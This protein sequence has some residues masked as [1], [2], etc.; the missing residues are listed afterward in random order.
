M[1]KK[2]VFMLA[3]LAFVIGASESKAQNK[4]KSS[5]NQETQTPEKEDSL[6]WFYFQPDPFN[7]DQVVVTATRTQKRIKDVPVITQVVTSKQILERGVTNIQDLLAQEVP[8]LNFQQVGFGT[9][10]DIQGLG[11]KH[12]LFLIDG[13]RIAGENGGNID[14]SRIN[15]SNV[16]RIEIVKGASSALYGSQA[17]GGVINIITKNAKQPFE[18]SGGVKYTQNNQRN[19]KGVSKED[20][21]WKHKRHVD[22]PNLNSNLSLGFNFGDFSM[23]TDV[24]Y[25][26][27]DGY[28]MYDKSELVKYYPKL[29]TTITQPINEIP[30][31]ISGY[32]DVN[33]SHKMAYKYKDKLKV[34]L[35]GS[36]YMLNKYDFLQD[37]IFEKSLDY[38]YGGYF[39]YNFNPKSNLKVSFHADNYQRSDKF[40]KMKGGNLI[41]KNNIMQPRL[42]YTDSQ[43][44]NQVMTAGIEFFRE[45]LY[46]DKFE[47][48]VYE[49]KAQWYL[50]AFFQ[51]DW[52]INKKLSLIGGL[53]ADY[54]KNYGFNVTPKVSFMAKLNPFILR[55]NYARGYRSPTIKELYMNWDHLGMFQ[56]IGNSQLK[57]ESNN[58]ISISGEY[59]NRW[60]NFN[61]N[62]YSNWFRN[63]IEGMWKKG[64]YQIPGSEVVI[65]RDEYHYVNVGKS[66]LAGVEAMAK[67]RIWKYFYLHGSYN[68]LYTSK[69]EQG[70]RLSSSS[71][72]SG[73]VRFE[74]KSG[75]ENFQT[76]VNIIGNIMGAKDF[77]VLDEIELDGQIDPETGKNKTVEAFYDAHVNTYSLWDLTVSQ[78]IYKYCRITLG[79]SN[80]FNFTADRVTFNTSTTPGRRFFVSCNFSF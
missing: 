32:E 71:P 10:I 2:L 22:K 61:V 69:D 39:E 14:Y 65:P 21:F 77:S 25:N 54:H 60:M 12:V 34:Q 30:T 62:V 50:T 28:Q 49:T 26:S 36:F 75:S 7:L 63:K 74:F 6:D 1:I 17:M 44:K 23:N 19:F 15:L 64:E 42:I 41:Y 66:H 55:F 52:S 80:I 11:S 37:N 45:S 33:V 16:E 68:Y 8:G 51:D 24:V 29:D 38:T 76:V 57:P 59:S 9:D 31:S 47:T 4:D 40:E 78:N 46:G 27:A 35:N 18:I 5:T 67:F 48:N 70:V 20:D 13:E 53:R 79:V 56:I 72:H 3:A 73:N 43:L 58:Y